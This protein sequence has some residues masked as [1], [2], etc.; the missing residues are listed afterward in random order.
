MA[1]AGK[2]KLKA[3]G[4]LAKK[5]VDSPSVFDPAPFHAQVRVAGK[6]VSTIRGLL[7]LLPS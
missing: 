1:L 3:S 7:A 4:Y 2:E 6:C 5:V